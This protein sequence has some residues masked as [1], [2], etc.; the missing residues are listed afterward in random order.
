MPFIFFL[1][2]II[3]IILVLA[4]W[5]NI[6]T[7]LFATRYQ[8]QMTVTQQNELRSHQWIA[9]KQYALKKTDNLRCPVCRHKVAH[10][11]LGCMVFFCKC[12][13]PRQESIPLEKTSS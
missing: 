10:H 9:Q 13:L 8:P 6:T 5:P 7:W 2:I 4:F 1:L 3:A 11:D 12:R